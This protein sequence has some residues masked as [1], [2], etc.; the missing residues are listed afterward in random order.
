MFARY[1]TALAITRIAVTVVGEITKN[2]DLTA[3]PTQHSIVWNVAPDQIIAVCKVN[4]AFRPKRPG[5][6]LFDRLVSTSPIKKTLVI[7]LDFVSYSGCSDHLHPPTLQIGRIFIEVHRGRRWQIDR[8]RL[9]L[10]V[11]WTDRLGPTNFR[12][13]FVD[14]KSARRRRPIRVACL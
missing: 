5:V 11:E 10:A 3:S 8:R 9:L 1:Q 14:R 6:K 13:G 12:L 2:A 7:N 4:R